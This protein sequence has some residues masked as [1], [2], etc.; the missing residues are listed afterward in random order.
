MTDLVSDTINRV[1][2][3]LAKMCFP[4]H[5]PQTYTLRPFLTAKPKEYYPN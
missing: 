4:L 5:I 2:L 1:R 3:Q